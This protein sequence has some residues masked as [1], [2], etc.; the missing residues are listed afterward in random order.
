M[1]A[2]EIE[3][4]REHD[5]QRHDRRQMQQS[6]AGAEGPLPHRPEKPAGRKEPPQAQ[7]RAKPQEEANVVGLPDVDEH[8][9]GIE[10]VINGDGVE[11]RLEFIEEEELHKEQEDLH[12]PEAEAAA[13]KQHPV[14]EG[15][16]PPIRHEPQPEQ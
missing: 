16:E 7:H 8:L 4:W 5:D 13:E 6:G 15:A 14:P 12:E 1:R 2:S 9:A 3:G 10:E 11:A